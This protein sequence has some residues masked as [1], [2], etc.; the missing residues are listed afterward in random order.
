MNINIRVLTFSDRLTDVSG[1]AAG[2]QELRAESLPVLI[3]VCRFPD[4][5]PGTWRENLLRLASR[6]P[7]RGYRMRLRMDFAQN[8]KGMCHSSEVGWF[9]HG[10]RRH[11][12]NCSV[13]LSGHKCGVSTRGNAPLLLPFLSSQIHPPSRS[14][15]VSSW[16]SHTSPISPL[17]LR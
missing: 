8:A 3:A 4:G 14:G 17:D 6:L 7:G 2:L 12:A 9:P 1:T 5:R 11:K 10:K 16:T 15:R 13:S